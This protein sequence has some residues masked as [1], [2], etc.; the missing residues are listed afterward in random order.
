VL[1]LERD[2][3]AEPTADQDEKFSSDDT[4]PRLD[5]EAICHREVRGKGKWSREGRRSTAA[6]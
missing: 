5:L 4:E 1:A 6:R 3:H 2:E